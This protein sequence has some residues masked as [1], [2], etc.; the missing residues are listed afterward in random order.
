MFLADHILKMFL[1]LL[2]VLSQNGAQDKRIDLFV[3]FFHYSSYAVNFN[4]S[5]FGFFLGGLI[6][7]VSLYFNKAG[8]PKCFFD[9]VNT[10]R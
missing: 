8:T 9:E 4:A 2:H 7:L 10:N 1:V 3:V 5:S 6:L